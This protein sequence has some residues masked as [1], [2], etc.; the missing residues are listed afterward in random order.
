MESGVEFGAV[1]MPQADKFTVHIR[2]AVAEQEA[3]ATS[4]RTRAALVAAK[5]R[6]KVL[7][8]RRVSEARFAEIRGSALQAKAQ[9]ADN[10]RAVILPIIVKIQAPGATSLRQIAVGLNTHEI[11]TPRGV[12]E[13]S[14]VQVQWILDALRIERPTH[15]RPPVEPTRKS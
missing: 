1:D 14:A 5:A 15:N 10:A 11:P 13:W 7:G 2:A 3:E 9:K 8:G 12:G 6:G 4:R